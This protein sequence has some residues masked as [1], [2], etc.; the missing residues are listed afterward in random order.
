MN[1]QLPLA[2]VE[3]LACGYGGQAVVRGIGLTVREGEFYALIGVNGSGKSTFLK[4]IVGLVPAVTGSIRF[5]AKGGAVPSIGYIPQTEKLDSIF[6][7]SVSEVVLMGTYAFLGPGKRV[8]S[9]HRHVAEAAL[10]RMGVD[11]LSRRRFSELSGGQKQRVLLARALATNPV[12]LILDEP[13]SGVD[14]AAERVFMELIA[15]VNHRGVAVLMASHNLALVREFATAVMWFHD[16]KAEIGPTP[17]IFAAL[18][19]P[20][21]HGNFL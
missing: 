1:R 6:P 8:K 15:E 11:N 9:E 20:S 7:I 16:G 4:T 2:T 5:A 12:L 17:E 14:Q 21:S 10:R 19:D 3:D 18:R 13:T